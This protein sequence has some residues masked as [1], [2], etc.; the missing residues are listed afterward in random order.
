MTSKQAKWNWNMEYQKAFDRNN[1]LLFG[2]TLFSY[3][4]FNKCFVINID[5]SRLQLGAIISQ[6]D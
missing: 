6:D 5:A 2:E 3:P 1:M 4:N